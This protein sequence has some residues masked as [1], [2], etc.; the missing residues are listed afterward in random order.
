MLSFVVIDKILLSKQSFLSEWIVWPDFSSQKIR[1]RIIPASANSS[2]LAISGE[3]AREKSV[4]IL[5]IHSLIR[6]AQIGP[7]AK[8]MVC[9]IN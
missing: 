3:R 2:S 4:K 9:G 1:P 7:S 5:S 8:L 6:I